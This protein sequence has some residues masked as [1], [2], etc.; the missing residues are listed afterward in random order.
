[1]K[2]LL[3]NAQL[4]PSSVM[5]AACISA[6]L[7]VCL[8]TGTAYAVSCG[9]SVSV[10]GRTAKND[11]GPRRTS[12]VAMVVAPATSCKSTYVTRKTARWPSSA[13]RIMDSVG[14]CSFTCA[15]GGDCFVGN[16][17]LPVEL[18][19]FGVE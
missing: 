12:C 5:A 2:K 3:T 8:S 11:S 9:G 18:L 6:T 17:G 13:A 4:L 16:D 10:H 7:V 1:M 15:S 19:G 14:G